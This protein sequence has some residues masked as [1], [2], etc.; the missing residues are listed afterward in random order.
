MIVFERP[1]V[2]FTVQYSYKRIL[3]SGGPVTVC[4]SLSQLRKIL[5]DDW[6]KDDQWKAGCGVISFPYS[7]YGKVSFS[8]KR[9]ASRI[10]KLKKQCFL[11]FT[12]KILV[13]IVYSYYLVNSFFLLGKNYICHSSR[14]QIVLGNVKRLVTYCDQ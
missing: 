11:S 13:Y 8:L 14:L 9:T 6:L 2:V 3:L 4:C 5:V 7:D 10:S 12:I 1:K